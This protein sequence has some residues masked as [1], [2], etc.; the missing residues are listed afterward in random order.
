MKFVFVCLKFVS[1]YFGTCAVRQYIFIKLLLSEKFEEGARASSAP[2]HLFRSHMWIFFSYTPRLVTQR[3]RIFKSYPSPNKRNTDTIA[4]TRAAVLP[5]GRGDYPE[6]RPAKRLKSSPAASNAGDD[7]T[8]SQVVRR[9]PL[10]VRPSGNALTSPTN[11]KAHCGLFGKL[12]DELIMQFL[13]MLKVPHLLRLG[14]TC[15]ALHAFTRNEE[16]WKALF[17][18]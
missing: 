1:W 9:H 4:M 8:T 7:K 10:G 16:L 5:D 13:E 6:T 14:A 18:E 17:I 12:P 11:L 2:L 15:R 3:W